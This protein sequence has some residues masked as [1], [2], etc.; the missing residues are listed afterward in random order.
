MTD[1]VKYYDDLLVELQELSQSIKEIDVALYLI[2][3]KMR[4]R[5][6]KSM[7]AY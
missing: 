2:V 5:S 4:G 1:W 3:K 6:K 7:E